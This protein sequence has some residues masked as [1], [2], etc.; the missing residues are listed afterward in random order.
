MMDFL[1]V[2]FEFD[3]KTNKKGFCV[4]R[5]KKDNSHEI[6]K[7]G[8]DEQADIIYKLLTIPSYKVDEPQTD[9]RN[10]EKIDE[11]INKL[12]IM[13]SQIVENW[14]TEFN[15]RFYNDSDDYIALTEC[16]EKCEKCINNM[17]DII[18]KYIK[19]IEKENGNRPGKKRKRIKRTGADQNGNG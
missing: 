17:L 3:E 19:Q 12:K 2:S 16:D 9:E 4:G 8:F 13:R 6:L 7:I 10:G 1:N 11:I 18:D 5:A 15:L 14:C